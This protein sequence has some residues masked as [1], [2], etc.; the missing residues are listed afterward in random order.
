MYYP[1]GALYAELNEEEHR[2]FYEDGTLKTVEPYLDG[3]LHGVVL[4]YWPNGKLK[5]KVHFQHGIRKG[6]DQMYNMEGL[7]VDEESY[8]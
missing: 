4:L 2:Y 3:K 7:L 8:V 5:R 6:Q 1:S